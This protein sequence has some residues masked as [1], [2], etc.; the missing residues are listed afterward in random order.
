MNKK[1]VLLL[2]LVIVLPLLFNFNLEVKAD[3]LSPVV[4]NSEALA[5]FGSQIVISSPQN[6]TYSL[7]YVMLT[8]SVVNDGNWI[9]YT[10]GYSVDGGAIQT[11]EDIQSQ[12][13]RLTNQGVYPGQI[14]T[15]R[16]SNNLTNLQEGTHTATVYMGAVYGPPYTYHH[17]E[18]MKIANVTFT[19]NMTYTPPVP[20]VYNSF[21]NDFESGISS[22]WTYSSLAIS[23][24]QK[25]SGNYSA[26]PSGDRGVLIKQFSPPQST[27]YLDAWSYI[28]NFESQNNIVF[29]TSNQQVELALPSSLLHLYWKCYNGSNWIDI[30]PFKLGNW[31]HIIISVDGS[32]GN[33]NYTIDGNQTNVTLNSGFTVS[34]VEL[35]SNNIEGTAFYDDVTVSTNIPVSTP[36]PTQLPTS[37]PTLT[38]PSYWYRTHLLTSTI[39]LIV[40][41]I[42]ALLAVTVI[43]VLLYRRH[44]R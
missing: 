37:T 9:Y 31:Q 28:D 29:Y 23:T 15:W 43:S 33:V 6:I 26:S 27:V 17:F 24:A 41:L 18:V 44:R 3:I 42:V 38:P 40:S 21:T 16:G 35:Q 20:P 39:I 19:V 12:S 8:F 10:A 13:Q 34:G 5:S 11:F 22:N 7:H 14:N 4:F 30:A 36:L 1:T 25:H 32:T 2:V